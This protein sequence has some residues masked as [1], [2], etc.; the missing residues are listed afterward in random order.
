[1]WGK[2]ENS[3]K[4]YANVIPKEKTRNRRRARFF[5]YSYSHLRI[6]G[7]EQSRDFGH[8]SAA[9]SNTRE[10]KAERNDRLQRTELDCSVFMRARGG[11]A[12]VAARLTDRLDGFWPRLGHD[13][14]RAAFVAE[15]QPHLIGQVF[16]ILLREEIVAIDKKQERR[17]RLLDLGGIEEFQT[18][19]A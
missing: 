9:L 18:M 1:M 14:D 2:Q 8:F 17:W 5:L 6:S 11:L 16:L 3:P 13:D 4:S 10:W 15:G 12:L 19:A 7:C